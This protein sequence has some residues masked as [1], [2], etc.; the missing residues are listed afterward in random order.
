[1][2]FLRIGLHRDC[3]FR[4]TAIFTTV[5]ENQIIF[6]IIISKKMIVKENNISVGSKIFLKHQVFTIFIIHISVEDLI[7]TLLKTID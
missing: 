4:M 7:V 6:K 2:S 1:M 5:L 3:E